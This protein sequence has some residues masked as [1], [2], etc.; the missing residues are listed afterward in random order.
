MS[1]MK[2]S[3][4]LLAW[5]IYHVSKACT[6]KSSNRTNIRYY[7]DFQM[8]YHQCHKSIIGYQGEFIFYFNTDGWLIVASLNYRQTHK[9][10]HFGQRDVHELL[11]VSHVQLFS[12]VTHHS[13]RIISSKFKSAKS[14]SQRQHYDTLRIKSL[15]PVKNTLIFLWFNRWQC[16]LTPFQ[17]YV[18]TTSM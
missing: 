4:Q 16:V 18:R 8:I 11:C 2:E 1:K 15:K 17:R 9:C 10:Y 3:N 13:Y 14:W 5:K 6:K 12:V 7:N